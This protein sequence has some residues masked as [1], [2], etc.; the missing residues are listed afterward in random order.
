MDQNKFQNLRA[1]QSVQPFEHPGHL[2]K[3]I[4]VSKQA[5]GKKE[6]GLTLTCTINCIPFLEAWWTRKALHLLRWPVLSKMA[7][8][9]LVLSEAPWPSV[10]F[11]GRTSHCCRIPCEGLFHDITRHHAGFYDYSPLTLVHRACH[12]EGLHTF[13]VPFCCVCQLLYGFGNK[14]VHFSWKCGRILAVALTCIHTPA[15]EGWV[16]IWVPF[17]SDGDLSLYNMALLEFTKFW[18]PFLIYQS[19]EHPIVSKAHK[20]PIRTTELWVL[21]PSQWPYFSFSVPLSCHGI[22]PPPDSFC[23]GAGDKE[24]YAV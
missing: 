17:I 20:Y 9:M 1:Q 22:H 15:N 6:E 23:S 2:V 3:G 5:R 16:R 12:F 21:Y 14:V 10:G 11:P 19:T 8:Q 4:A 18:S 7:N 13:P 24:D